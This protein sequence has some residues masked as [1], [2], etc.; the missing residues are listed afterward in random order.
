MKTEKIHVILFVNMEK[1]WC[2][3][4]GEF[5]TFYSIF[6]LTAAIV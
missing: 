5:L 6:K 4:D 3:Y 1:S 2:P